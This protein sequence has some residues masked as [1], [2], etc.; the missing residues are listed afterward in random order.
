MLVVVHV[1]SP[2]CGGGA[3]NPRTK[4]MDDNT[5]VT[6][7]S[8]KKVRRSKPQ[9][10]RKPSKEIV[11]DDCKSLVVRKCGKEEVDRT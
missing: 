9:E 10:G 1:D 4:K 3:S 6:T 7:A 5:H 8:K 2:M 11:C